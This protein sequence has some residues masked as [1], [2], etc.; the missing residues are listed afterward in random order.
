MFCV[1]RHFLKIDTI[2]RRFSNLVL[3]VTTGNLRGCQWRV[4]LLKWNCVKLRI[5]VRP[6]MSKASWVKRAAPHWPSQIVTRLRATAHAQPPVSFGA[7]CSRARR[8]LLKWFGPFFIFCD[9]QYELFSTSYV[10]LRDLK[11]SRKFQNFFL[12]HRPYRL[13]NCIIYTTLKSVVFSENFG[14]F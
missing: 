1:Y 3:P 9:F 6:P 14:N 5:K 7:K 4:S 8:S 10:G 12:A 13:Q 11:I 2:L